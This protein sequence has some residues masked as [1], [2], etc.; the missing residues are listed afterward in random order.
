MR[1][2]R[3]WFPFVVMIKIP[4]KYVSLNNKS[5]FKNYIKYIRIQ[6]ML[7]YGEYPEGVMWKVVV[8]ETAT[9]LW[10]AGGKRAGH[11]PLELYHCARTHCNLVQIQNYFKN[12]TVLFEKGINILRRKFGI[13][14]KHTHK[15]QRK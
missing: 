4:S 2:K 15:I 3:Y 9:L 5:L 12:T 8:W 1:D 13:Y 7:V 10:G 14:R 6:V 11:R